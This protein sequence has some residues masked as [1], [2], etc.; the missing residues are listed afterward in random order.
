MHNIKETKPSPLSYELCNAGVLNLP[1]HTNVR[2]LGVAHDRE[3]FSQY[4]D[5]I[6]T[7]VK[8]SNF[9][10]S[11]ADFVHPGFT[12]GSDGFYSQLFQV[13]WNNDKP[14]ICTDP[15]SETIPYYIFDLISSASIF[16]IGGTEAFGIGHDVLANRKFT[17]REF[18]KLIGVAAWLALF[19]G[20]TFGKLVFENLNQEC[21]DV[22]SHPQLSDY[23]SFQEFRNAATV[24][25]LAHFANSQLAGLGEVQFVGQAH[26]HDYPSY[27]MP[28]AVANK[29]YQNNTYTHYLRL[30]NRVPTA[31]MWKP[32]FTPFM[33]DLIS[34]SPIQPV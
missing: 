5:A 11:E 19:R 3:F 9:V 30:R 25:G 15:L 8:D 31:R 21:G 2:L 16:A 26:T 20:T 4:Q 32:S 23:Y 22:T 13:A 6:S 33:F 34:Q 28:L 10:V 1:N 29:V 24:L 12:P 14:V 7:A 17:R 18:L 27:V